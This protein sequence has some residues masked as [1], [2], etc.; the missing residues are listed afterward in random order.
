M[1]ELHEADGAFERIEDY[2]RGHG[3]FAGRAG[4]DRC[5]DLFLGYGLSRTL[6][7][8]PGPDP[9]EPCPLPLAACRIRPDEA[10]PPEAGDFRI[11]RWSCTWSEDDHARAVEAVREAIARVVGALRTVCLLAGCR[12]A[13]EL[14]RAPRHLGAPLR[15]YL[16]DLGL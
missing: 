5:A 6:R 8:A 12:T 4:D 15:H 9:P 14:A 10:L 2:L 11:G 13:G 1:L 3:F 16:D 7:R